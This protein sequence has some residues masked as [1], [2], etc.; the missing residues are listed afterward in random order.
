MV[1]QKPISAEEWEADRRLVATLVAKGDYL[2]ARNYLKDIFLVIGP[3][4]E[5]YCAGALFILD[6][7][8][9]E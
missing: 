3:E 4:R 8:S 5:K 1:S 6:V 9:G 7:L 2:R